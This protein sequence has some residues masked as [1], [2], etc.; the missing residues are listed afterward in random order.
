M[1]DPGRARE[2]ARGP[3]GGRHRAP[4]VYDRVRRSHPGGA[5]ARTA[6]SGDARGAPRTRRHL[7]AVV[8]VA[9]C[10]GGEANAVAG[11][12]DAVVSRGTISDAAG[13]PDKRL[14]DG[15]SCNAP[16]LAACVVLA[17]LLGGCAQPLY[18][19][20]LGWTEAKI[21]WR[22]EPMREVIAEPGTDPALRERLEL[23]L[24]A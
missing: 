11:R 22:R 16:R 12:R 3:H 9:V 19:A 5:Q 20:R 13:P 17:V 10:G 4:P 24:A 15:W 1:A 8:P 7:R 6:R 23:V 2:V 14:S 18:V 21:L